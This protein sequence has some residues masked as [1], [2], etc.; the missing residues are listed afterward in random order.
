MTTNIQGKVTTST[1]NVDISDVQYI[2]N[3]VGAGGN[4]E[5]SDSSGDNIVASLGS[6]GV[7]Y[8]IPDNKISFNFTD[9]SNN[10]ISIRDAQYIANWKASPNQNSDINRE[11]NNISYSVHSYD[12]PESKNFRCLVIHEEI[13]FNGEKFHKNKIY[14]KQK[15]KLLDVSFSDH[16]LSNCI[17]YLSLDNNR[18]NIIKRDDIV[19]DGSGSISFYKLGFDNSGDLSR[20]EIYTISGDS[21]NSLLNLDISRNVNNLFIP[22]QEVLDITDNAPPYTYLG[23]NNY[24]PTDNNQENYTTNYDTQNTKNINFQNIG[25]RGVTVSDNNI[26]T[27]VDTLCTTT[28]NLLN[29][30]GFN[31]TSWF[32]PG[33][34][35]NETQ[36]HLV[37]EFVFDDDATGT[38]IYQYYYSADISDN[39]PSEKSPYNIYFNIKNG[40]L[41]FPEKWL[42]STD[43]INI[44]T[45]GPGMLNTTSGALPW[46]EESTGIIAT[47]YADIFKQ[48]GLKWAYNYDNDIVSYKVWENFKIKD[49][50]INIISSN[51]DNWAIYKND[52]PRNNIQKYAY[53]SIIGILRTNVPEFTSIFCIKGPWIDNDFTGQYSVYTSEITNNKAILKYI[54]DPSTDINYNK[55][56]QGEYPNLEFIAFNN[57]ESIESGTIKGVQILKDNTNIKIIT[58]PESLKSFDSTAFSNIT[59]LKTLVFLGD[60]KPIDIINY[61]NTK[62]QNIYY[63]KGQS[64]W[65]NQ[66]SDHNNISINQ[67]PYNNNSFPK[68]N[69]LPTTQ[70]MYD[71]S[72][73]QEINSVK[74]IG[75]VTIKSTTDIS[76]LLI[77][78]IHRTFIGPPTSG[79]GYKGNLN[80]INIRYGPTI[81]P[82]QAF[83][84]CGNLETVILPDSITTIDERAFANCYKLQTINLPNSITTIGNYAFYKCN[85]NEIIIKNINN[86]N[87]GTGCFNN[88]IT[89]NNVIFITIEGE[90]AAT[91]IENKVNALFNNQNN[92][93]YIYT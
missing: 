88:Q 54:W 10:N 72:Y 8:N 27:I 18:G 13:S 70:L 38:M 55:Y 30:L 71:I 15:N 37:G 20:N 82:R 64:G 16:I 35:M 9:P 51:S 86:I 31:K 11:F 57:L 47:I 12:Y 73:T 89:D 1:N 42:D 81:I 45:N 63:I 6:Q 26:F 77:T 41:E 91:V 17:P 43:N 83:Q 44:G 90:S 92:I 84:W 65:V 52:T 25:I 33:Q 93:T 87:F 36:G 48:E 3:W 34:N 59:N 61:T 68:F 75:Y 4:Q 32:L 2:L 5:N 46:A 23:V 50:S 69:L 76:E 79:Y 85:L 60:S 80:I 21:A 29:N 74:D 62:L 78:D 58:L 22:T 40:K 66:E 19:S 53:N 24:K 39:L 28:V 7:S 67:I 14:L 56:N 49:N